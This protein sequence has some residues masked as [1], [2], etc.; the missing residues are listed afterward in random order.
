[1]P[2]RALTTASETAS[3][4]AITSWPSTKS[5]GDVIGGGSVGDTIRSHHLLEA[6]GNGVLVVFAQENNGQIPNRSQID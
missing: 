5:P 4:I 6:A 2:A 3:Y 1:M